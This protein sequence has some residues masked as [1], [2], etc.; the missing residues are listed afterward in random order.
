MNGNYDPVLVGISV[1]I[2]MFASY[3]AL[4]L[5]NSVTVARGRTRLTWLAGGSL[6]MGVGIWSMHF[7]GML[8]FSLPGNRIA[9]DIPLLILSV[10]VAIGASAIALFVVSLRKLALPLLILAGLAMGAAICGMHYIGMASMRMAAD[11]E[12]SV[13]LVLASIVIAVAA[14]FAALSLAF[15]FREDTSARGFWRRA[16]GGVLMGVAISG[17]HYTA[18]AAAWFI[19]MAVPMAVQEEEVL[20]TDGLAIAVTLT[21]LL[22]LAIAVAGSVVDRA[23]ARRTAMAE[24]NAR[25]YREA[26]RAHLEAVAAR[27]TARETASRFAFLAEASSVLA[28][29]LDY[30]DTLKSIARLAVLRTADYC[31]VDV[32]DEDTEEIRRL[33]IAHRDPHKEA[34]LEQVEHYPPGP[35]SPLS[36]VLRTGEPKLVAELTDEMLGAIART[37]EHL[38]I[39]RAV[40]P[41]SMIVVPLLARGHTLGM[42]TFVS[43]EDRYDEEDFALA[44]E[45][46]R[47]AALAVDNA[48]LYKGVLAANQAKSDFLAVMSHELRTPLNAVVG[49]TDL[50]DLQ[51]AGPITN[52]QKAQLGRIKASARHLLDLIEEVLTFARLEAA[53]EEIRVERVDVSELVREVGAIT[54]PLAQEEGLR[55]QVVLPDAHI[56]ADTDPRRVRQILINLLSNAVKFTDEGEIEVT[57]RRENGTVLLQVRDTGLGIPAEYRERIFDAFWQVEQ[58]TTRRAGGTG[59][60]L[61]V[62]RRLAHLLGGDIAVDSMPGKGTSFTVRLPTRFEEARSA[63]QTK[64][65]NGERNRERYPVT[66]SFSRSPGSA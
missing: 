66:P 10:V 51:I 44:E 35:E 36:T 64:R 4:D 23:L 24:E 16:A 47:R 11:V 55:F 40:T 54:E 21:T 56:W 6:A 52:G 32:V 50:L 8:A 17:M 29:S 43:A 12:W 14:S 30:P 27:D 25:L 45:L 28:A 3:T 1:L 65:A 59:L 41:K 62:A 20:A 60:G 7:V 15:R 31:L 39:I 18:M 37:P 13:L 53:G 57:A 5:A 58:G 26:E 46:A 63:R 38:E 19:P 22:I 9:Y 33:A 49:Y 61:S 34:I 42:M 48:R 2:A